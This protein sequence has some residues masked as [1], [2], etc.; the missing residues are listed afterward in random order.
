MDYLEHNIPNHVTCRVTMPSNT[1]SRQRV[2]L[3]CDM[4]LKSITLMIQEGGLM[5][6]NGYL[7]K[8]GRGRCSGGEFELA[9]LL[10]CKTVQSAWEKVNQK[11]ALG[12]CSTLKNLRGQIVRCCVGS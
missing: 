1:T 12:N 5:G 10:I 11:S 9:D 7:R 3:P 6:V 2:A 4:C 8:E